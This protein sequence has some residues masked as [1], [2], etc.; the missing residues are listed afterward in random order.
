MRLK[1]VIRNIE[2]ISIHDDKLLA[3]NISGLAIDSRLVAPAELFIAL[4]GVHTTGSNFVREALARGAMAA[5]V[6]GAAADK[7]DD[8]SKIIIVKNTAEAFAAMSKNFYANPT[9]DCL[10]IGVTG[11]NG[12]TTITYLLESIFSQR[13]KVGVIGTINYRYGHTI[14]PS[15]YTTP[16]PHELMRVLAEMKKSKTDVVVMEVSSHSLEQY[17]VDG[18]EFDC[19]IFTN[20]THDH[21]DYHGNMENYFRAKARLFT[22][23]LVNSPKKRKY[24]II[25]VDDEWGKKLSA[26]VKP[27]IETIK[28]S[29]T[30]Q[31]DISV[32]NI[33]MSTTKTSFICDMFGR[34]EEFEINLLGRYNMANA[35]LSIATS[36]VLGVPLAEIKKGLLQ[37]KRIPGRMETLHSKKGFT[38][39]V[40][41]AH[42][43]DALIKVITTLKEL[44]PKRLITVFGCGGDRDRTKR[45]LMGAAAVKMSDF[46]VV[47]SDNPRTEDP[48]KIILDIELGI[49]KTG[50][51]NYKTILDRKEAI[52]YAVG[53]A[54]A[55]DIVLLA[56]KGH[57]PY[58]IIGEEKIPFNDYKTAEKILP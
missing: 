23:L 36:Y 55:G 39:V 27:A 21:L 1:N 7:I 57:E 42:T 28:C 40:D 13:K 3:A 20:L 46:V 29:M 41:Y 52:E 15:K 37:V 6:S 10:L 44:K 45:P 24:S 34:E 25:N 5:V 14:I 11:T 48:Y 31:S 26:M 33:K 19:G 4:D 53:M 58:Q 49:K 54:T 51:L 8:K 47:T 32:K 22:E 38:V 56:G 17:R 16:F 12:K 18:C 35:M 43:P 30:F 2:G 50:A 9:K